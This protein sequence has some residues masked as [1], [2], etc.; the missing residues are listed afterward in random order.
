[1]ITEKISEIAH[2]D[3]MKNFKM[4]YKI[5]ILKEFEVI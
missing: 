2:N 1:M 5:S 4:S 3:K